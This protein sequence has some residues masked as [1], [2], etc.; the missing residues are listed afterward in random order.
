MP[1]AILL[2][3]V[4]SLDD[5][6]IDGDEESRDTIAKGVAKSG[7]EK[8]VAE[9]VCSMVWKDK[10]GLDFEYREVDV[11]DIFRLVLESDEALYLVSVIVI[12]S[13]I[14]MRVGDDP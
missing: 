6:R 8:Q 5:G 13:V 2:E 10:Q 14:V 12:V 3:E 4:S 1:E 11:V 7:R 9:A